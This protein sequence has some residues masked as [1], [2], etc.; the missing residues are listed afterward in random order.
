MILYTIYDTKADTYT[1][2]FLAKNDDLA[3]R[4]IV[5]TCRG[6]GDCTLVQYPS[7]FVL[8]G[9]AEWDESTGVV[10]PF[11]CNRSVATVLQILSTVGKPVTVPEE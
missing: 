6:V 5:N 4:V 9:I 8:F 10:T 7:D 2:P 1:P 3:K 11:D